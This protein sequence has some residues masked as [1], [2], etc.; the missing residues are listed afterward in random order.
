MSSSDE[1]I[2]G[3]SRD[4]LN[5]LPPLL[6]DWKD[7]G[8]GK[9]SSREA[10]EQMKKAVLHQK[11]ERRTAITAT[12]FRVFVEAILKMCTKVDNPHSN[13]FVAKS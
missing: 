10:F 9:L 13:R 4:I 12:D 6:A 5:C 7:D 3:L 8:R 1:A 11:D 2:R